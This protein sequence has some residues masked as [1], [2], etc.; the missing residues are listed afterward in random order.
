TTLVTCYPNG[1]ATPGAVSEIT[2]STGAGDTGQPPFHQL[3]LYVQDDF[4]VTRKLTLN[5]GLRWDANI[6][7]L[8]DQTNNRTMQILGQLNEPRARAI[9]GDASALQRLTPSYKEFQ[10]RVGF[11]Y[12]PV[13]DG[14]TVI[15]GGY[16]IFYDQ[17]F[18]NLLLFAKQQTNPTIYQTVLDQVNNRVGTGQLA[19]FRFGVD[20]LPTPPASFN[21]SNLEFGGFGR[22]N[23][24]T[25]QDPYVQK[26][27]L[28]FEHSFGDGYVISSDFVHTIGIHENRVQNINPQIRSIC[29]PNYPGST[30]AAARCVRGASTRYFDQAFVQAGLG[31]GRLEQINMFTSTNR[32]LFDSWTTQLRRRMRHMQFSASYVLSNS[33]SWGG[34]PVASYTGNGIA[35][36][37]EQQ[38]RPEEF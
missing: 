15:R 37:P 8:V 28:G 31:A 35:V 27:S 7:L 6:H 5:L 1:F 29:D 10:P 19:T 38:F 12:D 21:T 13:G 17:L 26:F 23:D 22:I 14:K 24:P 11:A 33:R 34:Q 16:G 30:P 32:S 9:A 25:L 2:F 20:P 3:A 18:Q 36:T 4:K